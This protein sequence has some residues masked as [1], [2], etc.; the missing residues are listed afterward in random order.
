MSLFSAIIS[1][2]TSY[3]YLLYSD[4]KSSLSFGGSIEQRFNVS[5][6][7]KTA[8]SSSFDDMSRV[9]FNLDAKTT[10]SKGIKVFGYYSGEVFYGTSEDK[11]RYMYIGVATPY[12]AFSYGRQDSPQVVLTDTTN[13]METFGYS[14]VNITNGNNIELKNNFLYIV[15]LPMSLSASLNYVRSGQKGN[16]SGGGTLVYNSPL[17]IEFGLGYVSGEQN[18]QDANQY[19]I[20]AAYTAGDLYF[21]AIY[22]NGKV[23]HVDIDGYEL[24][25][26]YTMTDFIFRYVYNFR[27]SNFVS[28][29]QSQ[30]YGVNYNAIEVAYNVSKDFVFYAGYEFNKLA[31]AI[32]A[33]EFQVGA[34]YTY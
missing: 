21:G 31:G 27:T 32:N 1:S 2:T 16:D 12:G 26:Q 34:I 11:S 8:Q 28:S 24:A 6:A 33:D 10:V 18:T 25:A 20:T 5:D 4:D 23:N 7:N 22:V 17:G 30:F 13:I 19:S 3:A 14:A 29:L 9:K 15:Q